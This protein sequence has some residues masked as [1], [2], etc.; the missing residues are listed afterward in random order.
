WQKRVFQFKLPSGATETDVSFYNYGG[1]VGRVWV[2]NLQLEEG[3]FAT[4]YKS[5]PL[6]FSKFSSAITQ[7]VEGINTE[8]SKKVNGRDIISTI[9]QSAE[10]V[11]I[12]ASRIN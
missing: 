4:P 5:N 2:C 3:E 10:S 7:T 11:K 6:D 12:N 9:N 1:S 8:V